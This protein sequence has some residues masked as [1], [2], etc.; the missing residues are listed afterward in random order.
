MQNKIRIWDRAVRFYHW[1]QVALLGGLW[2]TGK[3]GLMAWHQ[4]LAYGLAAVLLARIAW[5]V[6]GSQS[7]R[8]SQFAASPLKALRYLKTSAPVA[9]HNPASFYMIITLIGLLLLQLLTGLATFDNTYMSDGPL[10]AYLSSDMVDLASR[11]HKLNIDLIIICVVIHVA[12][13]I[14]HSIRHQNVIGSMI[15]GKAIVPS[16]VAAP[17]MKNSW[18]YFVLVALLV[19]V[20]YLWQGKA[21]LNML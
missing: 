16:N 19:V 3:E 18:S 11:I 7:A 10:V 8:F 9:G 1:S 4:L 6:Y 20:F 14:W 2:Y 5:G 15:S 13:A 21:L 17:K 12:V